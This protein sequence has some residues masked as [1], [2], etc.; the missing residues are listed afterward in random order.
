MNADSH[1]NLPTCQAGQSLLRGSNCP[2]R[3]RKRDKE[4][5]TL[6]TNLDT[7]MAR[8]RVAKHSAVPAKLRRVPLGAKLIQ[9]PG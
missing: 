7:T 6:S 4:G 2:G 1:P 3:G 8:E 9:Q 5:V